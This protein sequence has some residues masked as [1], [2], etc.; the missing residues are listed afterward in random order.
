M[1]LPLLNKK[2]EYYS[3]K[4]HR[5]LSVIVHFFSKDDPLEVPSAKKLT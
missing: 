2:F 4:A 1:A 3:G 5:N